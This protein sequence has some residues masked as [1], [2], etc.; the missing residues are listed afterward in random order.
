[1]VHDGKN[2]LPSFLTCSSGTTTIILDLLTIVLNF[3]IDGVWINSFDDF[4]E[5]LMVWLDYSIIRISDP[6]RRRISAESEL[7]QR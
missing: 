4:G 7:N 3:A 5:S 2:L 1:M 6:I